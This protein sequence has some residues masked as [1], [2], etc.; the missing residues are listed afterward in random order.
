M[1]FVYLKHFQSAVSGISQGM[2]QNAGNVET[3]LVVW[4]HFSAG[5]QMCPHTADETFVFSTL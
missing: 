1:L 4:N 2:S 3:E 5:L